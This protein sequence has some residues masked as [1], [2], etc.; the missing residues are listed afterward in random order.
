MKNADERVEGYDE[1]D[2][3]DSISDGSVGCENRHFAPSS[4]S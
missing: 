4:R 2:S 1:V 3:A